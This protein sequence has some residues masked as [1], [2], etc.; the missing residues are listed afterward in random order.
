HFY[1]HDRYQ[2]RLNG[3]SPMEYRAKAV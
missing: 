1:N 2:K 3:L